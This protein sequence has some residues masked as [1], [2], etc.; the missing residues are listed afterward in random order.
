MITV[1]IT[2]H[3]QYDKEIYID[4]DEQIGSI[5]LDIKEYLDDDKYD[6]FFKF[7]K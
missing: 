3:N 1:H 5:A 4:I 2:F 7:K 6:N